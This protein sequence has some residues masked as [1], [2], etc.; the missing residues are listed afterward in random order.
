M[1]KAIE[2]REDVGSMI[3]AAELNRQLNTTEV[4]VSVHPADVDGAIKGT[5]SLKKERK[6][7]EERRKRKGGATRYHN[8]TLCVGIAD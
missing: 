1:V 2:G 3:L 7:K 6:K 4:Y 5:L 8:R